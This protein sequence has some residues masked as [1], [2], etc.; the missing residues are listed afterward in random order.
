MQKNWNKPL[1]IQFNWKTLLY[2]LTSLVFTRERSVNTTLP[3]VTVNHL[4]PSTSYVFNVA[5]CD[6]EG[7]WSE[8]AQVSVETPSEGVLFNS[9]CNSSTLSH[10][11]YWIAVEVNPRSPSFWSL[12]DLTWNHTTHG[13]GWPGSNCHQAHCECPT[14][15][16]QI[17][18]ITTQFANW[19]KPNTRNSIVLKYIQKMLEHKPVGIFLLLSPEL[20]LLI[21]VL[22]YVVFTRNIYGNANQPTCTCSIADRSALVVEQ[23]SITAA[24]LPPLLLQHRRHD[25]RWERHDLDR[26][27]SGIAWFVQVLRVQ[28]ESCG[29]QRSWPEYQLWGSDMQNVIRW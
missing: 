11:W 20:P 26:T 15:F 8:M 7:P 12:F 22:N 16:I 3:G 25:E 21:Q 2:C 18:T 27:T 4:K 23:S 29:V 14:I 13:S 5:A 9:W 24:L 19:R 17:I 6:G 10:V 28:S 1:Q